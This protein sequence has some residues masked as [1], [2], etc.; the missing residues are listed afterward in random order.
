M[1]DDAP[2]DRRAGAL[3]EAGGE[4]LPQLLCRSHQQPGDQLVLSPC[5]LVLVPRAPAAGPDQPAD[6]AADETTDRPLAA[7]RAPP[8]STPRRAVSV[9]TQ[10]RA[11][12]GRSAG[13]GLSGGRR[14]RAPYRT[15]CLVCFRVANRACRRCAPDPG[16]DAASSLGQR[17][18]H[19]TLR[20][21]PVSLPEDI[22]LRFGR[23]RLFSDAGCRSNHPPLERLRPSKVALRLRCS[24]P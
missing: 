3:P 2:A 20:C 16:A 21:L 17:H 18:G 19:R 12:C 11:Q 10:G 24:L 8:P 1:A 13:P 15:L 14:A 6:L 4:R 7:T 5:R 9:M 22:S 23:G